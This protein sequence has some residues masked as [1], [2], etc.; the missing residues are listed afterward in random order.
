GSGGGW[1]PAGWRLRRFLRRLDGVPPAS[2]EVQ[3]LAR[4]LA[5]RI[6]LRRCPT[7]WLVPAPVSPM[8]MALGRR[9]RLLVP[10]A[11]WAELG[12]EQ[13][14]TL[15]LH[16]LAHLRRGDPWVRR[17]ELVVLGLYWW[18]PVVWR[19]RRALQEA[20]EQCC[21]AWVVWAKPESAAEYAETLVATVA[22][23]SRARSAVPVG[24]SG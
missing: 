18:H 21:D 1:L 8:L 22:F 7:V 11:L 6:G 16:E 23:L 20:E 2:A 14:E 15:L 17:L 4:C 19:V 3:E 5:D 13:R 12:P 9:V 24:A 10:A